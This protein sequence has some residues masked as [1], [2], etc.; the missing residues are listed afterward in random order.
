[1]RIFALYIRLLNQREAFLSV[2]TKINNKNE[3]RQE[4]FK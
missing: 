3:Q 2:N 1:M 4:V